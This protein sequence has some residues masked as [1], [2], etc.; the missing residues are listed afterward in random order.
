MATVKE[1][2][3]SVSEIKDE[4]GALGTRLKL[5]ETKKDGGVTPADDS[6]L[7]SEHGNPRV[8]T[9]PKRWL[10]N[11][12]E[13]QKNKNYSDCPAEFLDQLAGFLI[14]QAKQNEEQA[15]NPEL[16]AKW[17]GAEK[18]RRSAHF[19]KLDAARALGWAKRVRAGY[20]PS[21]EQARDAEK[22]PFDE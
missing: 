21:P 5:L 2:E 20:V 1:L 4:L 11:D 19:K 14:W 6:D 22:L 9:D 15:N 17:G 13:S 10:E 16:A 8:Y 18:M 12:G 3:Q 7:D